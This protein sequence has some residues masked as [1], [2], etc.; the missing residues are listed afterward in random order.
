MRAEARGGKSGPHPSVIRCPGTPLPQLLH[1]CTQMSSGHFY[2]A[3]LLDSNFI[4]TKEENK[5]LSHGNIC[6]AY[7][8]KPVNRQGS[9]FKP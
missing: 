2:N 1:K 9:L 3:C 4:L 6:G 7:W 5:V 8:G